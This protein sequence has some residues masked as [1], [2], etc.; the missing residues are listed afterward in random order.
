[1]DLSSQNKTKS[2]IID[3]FFSREAASRETNIEYIMG[4]EE[5]KSKLKRK[6]A[7]LREIKCDNEALSHELDAKT[8]EILHSI[9]E[10][11][12]HRTKLAKLKTS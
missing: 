6:E 1:M 2:L 9:S 7:K 5:R 12:R 3:N 11:W 4:V 8:T 10:L